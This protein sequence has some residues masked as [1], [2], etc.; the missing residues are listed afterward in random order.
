MLLWIRCAKLTKTC[1]WNTEF[2]IDIHWNISIWKKLHYFNLLS[3]YTGTWTFSWFLTQLWGMHIIDKCILQTRLYNIY[4]W[5]T[6]SLVVVHVSLFTKQKTTLLSKHDM[7]WNA[8]TPLPY[9]IMHVYI[10]LLNIPEKQLQIITTCSQKKILFTKYWG[11]FAFHLS[12][13]DRRNCIY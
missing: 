13:F 1:A 5:I 6:M 8:I 10:I 3:K 4:K 2:L 11:M 12:K 7:L 9:S